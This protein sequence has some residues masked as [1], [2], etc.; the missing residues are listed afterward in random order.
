MQGFQLGDRL[1]ESDGRSALLFAVF[2]CAGLLHD[3]QHIRAGSGGDVA[4]AVCDFDV[5][6]L[7]RQQSFFVV[8]L[9]DELANGAPADIGCAIDF[10][11][12]WA[13]FKFYRVAEQLAEVCVSLEYA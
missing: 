10:K 1:R 13:F 7:Q 12:E 6:V 4:V 11:A 8:F 2:E 3:E 5:D 9:G